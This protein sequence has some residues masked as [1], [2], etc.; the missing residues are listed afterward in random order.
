MA[1]VSDLGLHCQ[2]VY[3]FREPGPGSRVAGD[4]TWERVQNYG[5]DGAPLD[6]PTRHWWQAGFFAA[7]YREVRTAE[8]VLA[9][10]GTD[11]AVDWLA[12]N[13]P[14]MAGFTPSQYTPARKAYAWAIHHAGTREFVLTGHSLGGGL[15]FLLS[16]EFGNPVVTF[17]APHMLG[18]GPH[19]PAT[20]G[21]RAIRQLPYNALTRI[22][23]GMWNRPDVT[24]MIHVRTTDDGVSSPG[25]WSF[26]SW[27]FDLSTDR[28]P[29]AVWPLSA[30]SGGAKKPTFGEVPWSGDR[31]ID[32]AAVTARAGAYLAERATYHFYDSHVMRTVNAAIRALPPDR[33]ARYHVDPPWPP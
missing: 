31:E 30:E 21:L 6:A 33:Q 19:P 7:L 18:V 12:S 28:F 15:V 16:A 29:G 4:S 2:D 27:L 14:L 32:D 20:S 8:Y 1:T 17:N 24:R 25:I 11:S 10:R 26:A 23:P 13:F 3:E 9:V 5:P 22:P